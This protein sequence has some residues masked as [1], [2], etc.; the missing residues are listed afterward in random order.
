MCAPGNEEGKK[1]PD[2]D[3]ACLFSKT[4]RELGKVEGRRRKDAESL[5]KVWHAIGKIENALKVRIV[6]P[7]L[8]REKPPAPAG[9]A[10]TLQEFRVEIAANGKVTVTFGDGKQVDLPPALHALFTA[11][12]EDAG[13]S[14]D[15]LVA[16]KSLKWLAASLKSR[17]HREVS[18]HAL[19]Q[20]LWRL[21]NLLEQK[22][23]G[24]GL[25]ES[26]PGAGARL[27]LKRGASA[28]GGA[29]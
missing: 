28:T 29:V 21:K 9:P 18:P 4:F 16:W 12:A 1:K 11:L 22:G 6:R 15:D 26:V 23:C 10:P 5:E 24:K 2:N 25:I 3:V 20:L 17:L 13:P 8:R 14:A 19:S 27:R 7:P